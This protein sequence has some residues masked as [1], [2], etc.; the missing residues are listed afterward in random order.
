MKKI[1]LLPLALLF[2]SLYSFAQVTFEG[3]K[4]YGRIFDLTYH[5]TIQNKV[6]AVTLGNH[7]VSSNDN[8]LNWEIYYTHSPSYQSI[9]KLKMIDANNISF[10]LDNGYFNNHLQILSLQT[11]QVVKTYILPIPQYATRTWIADYAIYAQNTDYA[12][13]SQGYSI[14]ASS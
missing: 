4:E 12:I 13:V 10:N 8:G 9:E 7:I 1:T 2:A 14:G 3:S 11:N 5:P 6:F